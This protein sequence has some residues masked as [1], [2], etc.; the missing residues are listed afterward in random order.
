MSSSNTNKKRQ[1]KACPLIT[2]I[3]IHK[4]MMS[5]FVF[6]LFDLIAKNGKP[7]IK[8]KDNI[9]LVFQDFLEK[10]LQVDVQKRYTASELL[11]ENATS[12]RSGVRTEVAR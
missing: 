3:D 12:V 7:N 4:V 1:N 9:S 10:C 6:Q 11:K 2:H 5:H 8:E